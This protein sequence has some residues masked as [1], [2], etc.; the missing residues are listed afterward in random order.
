MAAIFWGIFP[1]KKPILKYRNV[2]THA[3][4]RQTARKTTGEKYF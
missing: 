2:V 1:A 4:V 3:T